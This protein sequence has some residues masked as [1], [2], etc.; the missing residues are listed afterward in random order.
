LDYIFYRI[1][2]E[3]KVIDYQELLPLIDK[4]LLD[5]PGFIK[6]T[7]VMEKKTAKKVY[8][9]MKKHK[10]TTI[11]HVFTKENVKRILD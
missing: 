6:G 9:I 7:K 8:H 4:L 1:G 2:N 10:F 3:I 11:S 5:V